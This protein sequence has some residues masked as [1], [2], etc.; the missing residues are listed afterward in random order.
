MANSKIDYTLLY[1]LQD[2]VLNIVFSELSE[3]YLTGGTCLHRF[4]FAERYSDDLDFFTHEFSTLN[5]EV[6]PKNG[7]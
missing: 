5:G 2:K 4:Y 3:F 1:T 7:I 6:R